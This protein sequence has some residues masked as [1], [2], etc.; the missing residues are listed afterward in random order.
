MSA[1]SSERA[2]FNLP[3][4]TRFRQIEFVDR[5]SRSGAAG[6]HALSYGGYAVSAKSRAPVDQ[7]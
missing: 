5:R 3:N 2:S 1:H 6:K 7:E 4:A